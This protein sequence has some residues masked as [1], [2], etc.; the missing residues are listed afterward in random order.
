MLETRT[1]LAAVGGPLRLK[2][3]EEAAV[4][5]SAAVGTGDGVDVRQVGG[6]GFQPRPLRERALVE[7][8]KA[9]EHCFYPLPFLFYLGLYALMEI[10]LVTQS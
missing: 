4:G 1:P 5:L 2:Y 7:M 8:S 3:G 9:A 10:A 6:D